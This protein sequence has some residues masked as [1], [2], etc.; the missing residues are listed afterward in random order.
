MR[1]I[2]ASDINF[3]ETLKFPSLKHI[4]AALK[5]FKTHK[6]PGIDQITPAR[7]KLNPHLM[8]FSPYNVVSPYYSSF[9]P[10]RITSSNSKNSNAIIGPEQIQTYYT[11]SPHL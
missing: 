10:N 7:L 6:S 9:P 2:T 1:E 3:G 5:K 11:P 4:V 8:A